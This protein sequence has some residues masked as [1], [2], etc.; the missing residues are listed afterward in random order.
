[1]AEVEVIKGS[2]IAV[3]KPAYQSSTYADAVAGRA[4]DGNNNG[5]WSGGSINHTNYDAQAWWYVDLQSEQNISRIIIKNRTDTAYMS[6]LNDFWVYIKDE[7]GQTVW[8]NH[9]TT[10]PNPTV[11]LDTS[12]VNGRYVKVQLSGTNY[13][14]MA[15]VAVIRGN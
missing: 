14:H 1:M 4:C 7:N 11:T 3:G 12:G 15:D 13:L 5:T 8:T 10:Y 6:R 2:N 9:Q